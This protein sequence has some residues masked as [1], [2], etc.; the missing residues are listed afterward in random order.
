M[1]I[2]SIHP[3][4]LDT[5]GLVAL[6]REGLLAQAVLVGRV[7]GY[8]DHPQLIRF[9]E[10]EDAVSSIGAYLAAVHKESE[11]RGYSFNRGKIIKD[12]WNGAIPINQGQ[13]EYEFKWLLK[14]LELRD[15]SLHRELRS[16]VRIQPHPL[17]VVRSGDIE[18]WE[19]AKI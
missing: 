4:Y 9:V 2:W 1:R 14:K 17:F 15:K 18:P 16:I 10:T 11:A 12:S 3:R 6:W 19:R 7:K 8:C 5:K 13:L